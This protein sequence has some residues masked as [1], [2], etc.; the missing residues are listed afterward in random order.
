MNYRRK[1][2]FSL[3]VLGYLFCLY[4]GISGRFPILNLYSEGNFRGDGIG[5]LWELL[6]T[7][8][9]IG[10]LPLVPDKYY[11]KNSKLVNFLLVCPFLV[12][13]V[14]SLIKVYMQQGF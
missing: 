5:Y 8:C 12:L 11:R 7:F 1:V 6:G 10:M 3:L 9:W 2:L 13:T 4:A 14:V